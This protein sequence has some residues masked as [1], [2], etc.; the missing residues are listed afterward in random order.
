MQ[1][2]SHQALGEPG[3]LGVIS[4]FIRD[5]YWGDQA[6]CWVQWAEEMEGPG[7]G[8]HSARPPWRCWQWWCLWGGRRGRSSPGSTIHSPDGG[9][10]GSLGQ[11]AEGPGSAV[12]PAAEWPSCCP[13]QQR[14]HFIQGSHL[15]KLRL[16][17]P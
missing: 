5:L 9:R 3:N 2:S 6:L 16:S 4:P 17:V 8:M 15:W 7:R 13:G 14:E 11:A 10:V 12:N 1:N